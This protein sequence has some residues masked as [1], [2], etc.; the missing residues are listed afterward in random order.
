MII[1]LFILQATLSGML[2]FIDGL[3]SSC[4]E[5]R[6]I[7][8]TTNHKERLDPALLRPGRMD[9]HIEM[10]YCNPSGFR[11]LAKTY[12]G[13]EDHA[14]FGRV[15]ELIKKVDIS[16]AEMALHLMKSYDPTIA[17]ESLVEVLDKKVIEETAKRDNKDEIEVTKE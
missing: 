5:E 9:V 3:W 15:D 13:I 8:F 1:L 12:L 14:M 17:L 7:I 2:N 10:G 11:M 4:G 16:P 6:I